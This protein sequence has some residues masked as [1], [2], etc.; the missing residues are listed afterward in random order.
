M[1]SRHV[2]NAQYYKE[3]KVQT[4]TTSYKLPLHPGKTATI[5]KDKPARMW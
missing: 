4:E 2:R 3:Q 5:K 1:A